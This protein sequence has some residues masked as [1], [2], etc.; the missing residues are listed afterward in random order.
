M[1]YQSIENS[2]ALSDSPELCLEALSTLPSVLPDWFRLNKRSLPWREDREPYHVWLSEIMLQQTRVEAVKGYYSRFLSALPNIAALAAADEDQ[3]LKLWEGL[4]YYSRVKNLQK[5]AKM[6]MND[7]RGQFP[8]DYNNIRK[9]PGI[10]DYTAGAICSICFDAPTPAVDGNVLR[11]ISRFCDFHGCVDTSQV[12]RQFHDALAAVY[13]PKAGEF[14]QSLM[15]LGAIICLPN[16]TPLCEKCP[17]K[18]ACRGLKHRSIAQLPVRKEKKA[19]KIETMTV[20]LLCCDGRIAIQ[21]R[22]NQGLLAGL[23]EFP[24]TAGLLT[25]QEIISYAE[26]LGLEPDALEKVVN[27]HHIFTH[28]RWNMQGVKLSCSKQVEEF[29]WIQPKEFQE[30][31]PLPTAFRQFLPDIIDETEH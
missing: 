14:T 3:L 16:G 18:E 2:M 19:K 21:K 7:Y 27:R 25:A 22:P 29:L 31:Y 9:L 11:V 4:G 26:T 5:A 24:H 8:T 1:E 30:H 10:G 6:I 20:L 28:I 23:Y 15:E 17:L 13:P 12:R